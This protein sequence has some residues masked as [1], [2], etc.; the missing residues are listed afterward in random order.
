MTLLMGYYGLVYTI[1]EASWLSVGFA[2]L[3]S[4]PYVYL[5]KKWIEKGFIGRTFIFDPIQEKILFGG[6]EIARFA[7]IDFIQ[8]ETRWNDDLLTEDTICPLEIIFTNRASIQ[9]K[10]GKYANVYQL[11]QDLA[12]ITHKRFHVSK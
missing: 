11:G 9:V 8:L 10:C 4:I 12:G 6:K 1:R 7:D 5:T 3:L 2:L